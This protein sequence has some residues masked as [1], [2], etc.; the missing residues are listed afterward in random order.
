MLWRRFLVR[1]ESILA[2]LH[3]VIQIGFGWTDSHLHRFRIRKKSYTGP[4]IE[5][6]DGHDARTVRLADL[7]FRMNER[8]LY[9]FD[10][11]DLWQHEI[12]IERQCVLERG[13]T[14]SRVRGR[15]VGGAAGGLRGSRRISGATV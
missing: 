6:M 5:I 4:W 15:E 8:F 3:C 12:R 11:G 10:F 1:A 7:K 13:R 9:E 2:D 14:Y